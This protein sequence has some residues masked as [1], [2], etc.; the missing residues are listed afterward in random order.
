[1]SVA[2]IPSGVFHTLPGIQTTFQKF[3]QEFNSLV[4]TCSPRVYLRR[5]RILP[6]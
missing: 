3:P 1:M 4:R 5:S 2:V 6:A